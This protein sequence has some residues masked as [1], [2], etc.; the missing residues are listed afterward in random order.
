[1]NDRNTTDSMSDMVHLLWFIPKGD[2][3]E[4]EATLIGIYTQELEAQE[5][6]RRLQ[7][8]PGFVDYPQGFRVYARKL[9]QDTWTEGFFRY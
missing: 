5:A 1:M 7:A 4:E 3:D 6:I 9:N 8:K 2:E